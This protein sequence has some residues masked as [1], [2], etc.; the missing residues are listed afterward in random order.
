ME[1]I[2]KYMQHASP[3]LVVSSY[4]SIA[5]YFTYLAAWFDVLRRKCPKVLMS[6]SMHVSESKIIIFPR[7]ELSE[8]L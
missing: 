4:C 6:C 7:Y 2:R 3:A 5:S 1:H 8:K